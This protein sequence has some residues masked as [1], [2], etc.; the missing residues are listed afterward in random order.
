MEKFYK[1]E[2]ERNISS[3]VNEI[4]KLENTRIAVL[5]KFFNEN[6]KI[7]MGLIGIL[8]YDVATIIFFSKTQH[9][10]EFNA[11]IYVYFFAI[12]FILSFPLF[13]QAIP[14][15][16]E[17]YNNVKNAYKRQLKSVLIPKLLKSFGN[18]EYYN[19]NYSYKLEQYLKIS[20][21]FS[22]VDMIYADDVFRGMYNGINFEIIET[23]KNM[24]IL[25]FD[26]NKSANFKTIIETKNK[27][28]NRKLSN[29]VHVI[30]AAVLLIIFF[31][32]LLSDSGFDWHILIVIL[33]YSGFC[34]LEIITNYIKVTPVITE[35]I[36]I[37]KYFNI[38]TENQIEARYLITPAF[39]ERL[40]NLQ[41]AFGTK[42]INCSFVND[43]IIFA[44]P[45][46]KDLFEVG[47]LFTPLTKLSYMRT[48]FEEIIS[49]YKMI[50]H[51]K[52][53][54]RTGL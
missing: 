15:I 48:F 50:D 12:F 29:W 3:S 5:N 2:F 17:K 54:E 10:N 49:I 4:K 44:I 7:A 23:D 46:K 34:I 28:F 24:L 47:N 19:K 22:S 40:Q 9:L 32:G 16:I 1:R 53:N 20:G 43:K 38:Y 36:E 41:T 52:L 6:F 11:P 39:I 13:F 25:Y 35:D 30:C 37:H 8:I 18:I 33:F 51:F 14:I 21:L 31:Y 26:L 27:T 45:T 42:N